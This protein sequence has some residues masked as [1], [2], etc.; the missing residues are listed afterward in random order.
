MDFVTFVPTGFF[1][2]YQ[3]WREECCRCGEG[4]VPGAVGR[5]QE[6]NG[7]TT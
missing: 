1:K 2:G 4:A 7:D 6:L 3:A 5:D